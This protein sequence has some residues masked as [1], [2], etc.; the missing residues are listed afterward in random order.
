MTARGVPTVRPLW[1]EFPDDA[2][3]VGINNQ[4]LFGTRLLVAPVT[5]QNQVVKPI[6]LVFR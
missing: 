1:W 5:T 4:Y 3:T 6:E 2:R